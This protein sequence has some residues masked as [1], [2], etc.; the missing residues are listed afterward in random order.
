MRAVVRVR[1]R[2]GFGNASKGVLCRPSSYRGRRELEARPRQIQVPTH[3]CRHTG[4]LHMFED[5]HMKNHVLGSVLF[6]TLR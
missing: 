4:L 1:L 2:C 5:R 6:E 3:F